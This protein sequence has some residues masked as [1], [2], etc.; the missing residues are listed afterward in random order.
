MKVATLRLLARLSQ[1]EL[2]LARANVRDCE[3]RIEA[4]EAALTADLHALPHE[5]AISRTA[6]EV[7]TL[8]TWLQARQAGRR[9]AEEMRQE[10]LCEREQLREVM[11]ARHREVKRI[12]TLAERAQRFEDEER[13]QRA[14]RE[15]DDIATMRHANRQRGRTDEPGR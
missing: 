4:L 1:P 12:E 14:A 10:L 9:V 2:D 11:F 13:R 7:A 6:E 5:I 3:L 8:G 15:L